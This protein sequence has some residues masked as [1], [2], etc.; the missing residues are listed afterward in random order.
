M[1]WDGSASPPRWLV[2]TEWETG[3]PI[4]RVL[5]GESARE[6]GQKNKGSDSGCQ[7]MFS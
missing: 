2:N 7:L 4:E 5:C 3:T 1:G 6:M